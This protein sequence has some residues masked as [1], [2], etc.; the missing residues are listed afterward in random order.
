MS[1]KKTHED[2]SGLSSSSYPTGSA[3]GIKDYFE[4]AEGEFEHGQDVVQYLRKKIDEL[5]DE[6]NKLKNQ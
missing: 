2:I 3:G 1:I 4:P 5:V 6:V